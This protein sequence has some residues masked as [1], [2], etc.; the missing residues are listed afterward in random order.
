[1]VILHRDCLC[2]VHGCTSVAGRQGCLERP[3][4]MDVRSDP[5]E[6]MDA[7]E[8]LTFIASGSLKEPP[9]LPLTTPGDLRPCKHTFE[10]E[11]REKRLK[12]T[13]S[14]PPCSG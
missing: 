14:L 8:T 10:P 3:L 13:K 4:Y 1:M 11:H 12:M 9:S 6:H 5:R 2:A 7:G